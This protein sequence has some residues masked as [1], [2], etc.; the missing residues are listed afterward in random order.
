[1]DVKMNIDRESVDQS[2]AV[3]LSYMTHKQRADTKKSHQD[4]LGATIDAVEKDNWFWKLSVENQFND[5]I[6]LEYDK[7]DW[8]KI[9]NIL[10]DEKGKWKNLILYVETPDE[11][12]LALFKKGDPT[13]DNNKPITDAIIYGNDEVVDVLLKEKGV[14]PWS[15]NGYAFVMACTRGFIGIV[16]SLLDMKNANPGVS[17]SIA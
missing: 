6:K 12:K 2:V 13:I 8:S 5:G 14:D 17:D 10:S 15:N 1:M 11:V 3:M 4:A 9:Y 16:K 7:V